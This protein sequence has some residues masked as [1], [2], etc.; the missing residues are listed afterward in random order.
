MWVA[1]DP[2]TRSIRVPVLTVGP[3][4]AYVFRCTLDTGATQTVLPAQYLRSLGCDLSQP[5]SRIRIRT[6]TGTAVCPIVRVPHVR[7][8]GHTRDDFLVA[9]QDFPPGVETDG[10]LGLD[11][12]RGLILRLDFARGRASLAA[13][14][15]W[16][17]WR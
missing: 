17:L 13:P 4:R 10:L 9:A 12:Y 15:W 16:R 5:V 3:Q 1:F 11:F 8:L 2:A 7:A 6:A 14:S